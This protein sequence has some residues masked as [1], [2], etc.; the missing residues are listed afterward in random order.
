L[1]ASSGTI[2]EYNT[3]CGYVLLRKYDWVNIQSIHPNV[4]HKQIR[5]ALNILYPEDL[6]EGIN[7]KTIF[8]PESVGEDQII[9]TEK[10]EDKNE[11]LV[12]MNRHPNSHKK[13][14]VVDKPFFIPITQW[15]VVCVLKRGDL[16]EL[17][18][19]YWTNPQI[20][21]KYTANFWKEHAFVYLPSYC[22]KESLS[23]NQYSN[24]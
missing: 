2:A 3:R 9:F 7:V 8:L 15:F 14:R 5:D 6:I 21:L 17:R 18:T 24:L 10:V 16:L 13:V 11:E 20:Q 23:L 19:A 22:A 4:E 12:F 1:I